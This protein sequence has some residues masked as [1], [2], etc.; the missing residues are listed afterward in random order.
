MREYLTKRFFSRSSKR[1]RYEHISPKGVLSVDAGYYINSEKA[2]SDARKLQ[3]ILRRR[4]L[5]EKG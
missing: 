5:N 1:D 2:Q 3:E 4:R